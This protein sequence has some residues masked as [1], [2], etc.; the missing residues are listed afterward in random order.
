MSCLDGL[1]EDC[2]TEAIAKL[3]AAGVQSAVSNLRDLSDLNA[4]ELEEGKTAY[5][6]IK[7]KILQIITDS[8]ASDA[9]EK[10]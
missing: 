5:D 4:S 2:F 6:Q 3:V 7:D 1:G 9:I 10:K 8:V